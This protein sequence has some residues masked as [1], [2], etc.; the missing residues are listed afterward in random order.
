[1]VGDRYFNCAQRRGYEDAVAGGEG[2]EKT[3]EASLGAIAR[4]ACYSAEAIPALVIS[5]E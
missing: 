2:A 3:E 4:P 5:V 1:M